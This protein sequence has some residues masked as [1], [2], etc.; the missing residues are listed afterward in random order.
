MRCEKFVAGLATRCSTV[1]VIHG[2]AGTSNLSGNCLQIIRRALQP[3][4][5]IAGFGVGVGD[6]IH[7]EDKNFE[8]RGCT[9][10]DKCWLGGFAGVGGCSKIFPK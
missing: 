2:L 8:G 4:I 10:F 9:R 5:D 3:A 7:L 1:T 6:S